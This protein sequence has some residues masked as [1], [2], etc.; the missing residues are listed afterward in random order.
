MIFS[1]GKPIS[2]ITKFITPEPGDVILIGQ[3]RSET[4]IKVGDT[5]EAE[6]EGI[7][8]LRNMLASA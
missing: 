4:G 5:I 3:T 8:M 7:G 6:V 1:I 2:D